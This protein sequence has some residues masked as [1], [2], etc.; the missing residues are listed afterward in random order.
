MVVSL[1]PDLSNIST[2]VETWM[3]DCRSNHLECNAPDPAIQQ[4]PLPTRVLE[5]DQ[6]DL[7]GRL[8]LLHTANA[9]GK[10]IALSHSWGGN[11]PAKTVTSNLAARCT[12]FP[13]SELPAT[14]R[15]AIAVAM[16]LGIR[17]IWIDSLC[18]VQDDS[19]DWNREAAKMGD[20][21]LHSFLTIAA[22]RATNSEAGFLGSRSFTQTVKLSDVKPGVHDDTTIN[23][24]ACQR[25]SFS[26]D[27]DEGPLNRRAWVLQERVLSPRTLHFT[28][29][30]IYWECW[31]YHQG[32]DLEYKYLGVMK[33][34]SYPVE[35]SPNSLLRDTSSHGSEL[36]RGWWYMSSEYSSCGL[37]FQT[38]KLI[39]ISGLVQKLGSRLQI[40]YMKGIWM[41]YLH[42][43]VLWSA[44]TEDLEYLPLS[45][46]PSWSW[47][48]RKGPITYLQLYD[49]E[50]SPEFTIYKIDGSCSPDSL[51]V[52]A[53][54]AKLDPDLRISDVTW[55]DPVTDQTIFPPQLSYFATRYRVIQNGD[56]EVLGWMTL[57][58][59]ME[60]HCEISDLYWVL[61]AKDSHS[62]ENSNTNASKY[63]SEINRNHHCLIVKESENGTYTRVGVSSV[64]GAQYLKSC[65]RS[66]VIA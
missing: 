65:N 59:E 18:I 62:H 20:V 17:Y 54:L 24:N 10:Y 50:S 27:V 61:V 32:E 36:P 19:K 33:K 22:T 12:G 25:R 37:T 38:D 3:G 28:D 1:V 15:D 16:K 40:D 66:V 21:Y 2:L 46:A 34:V 41:E 43:G 49:F 23:I 47:A 6:V 14:F 31:Q 56:G 45:E 30:Q 7:T 52:H 55:S 44:R 63:S 8:R 9:T 42:P 13:L 58:I 57:D 29:H 39:A 4:P 60:C 35:L 53:A 5:L 51:S 48:S 64:T 11:Q 26:N